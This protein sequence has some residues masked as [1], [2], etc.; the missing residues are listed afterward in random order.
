MQA[1]TIQ[2]FEVAEAKLG[3]PAL[4]DAKEMVSAKEPDC[5]SVIT[6]L[7][8]FYHL[9]NRKSSGTLC[10]NICVTSLKC[11]KKTTLIDVSFALIQ[12]LPI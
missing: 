11:L 1:C 7:F 5:L 4:L 6:Y 12:I 9:F 3:I 8:H 10:N 2:A